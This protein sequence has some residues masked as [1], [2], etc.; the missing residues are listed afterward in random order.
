[1]KSMMVARAGEHR[2]LSVTHRAK[3]CQTRREGVR[4]EGAGGAGNGRTGP[5]RRRPPGL[6]RLKSPYRDGCNRTK[7]NSMP[8][9]QDRLRTARTTGAIVVAVVIA[10]A[11]LRAPGTHDTPPPRQLLAARVAAAS[12]VR[13]ALDELGAA[14]AKT[15]AGVQ[16]PQMSYG[17][18]GTLYA[19]IMNGAP[20]DLFLSA[21]MDYPRQLE[22]AGKAVPGT[23]VAYATGR[24]ALWVT[25]SSPLEVG[26]GDLGVV[27]DARVRHVALANSVHAPYGRAA[28]AA[29]KAAGVYDAVRPRLV[30]GESVAQ[31]LQFVQ[32]GA[33]D[34]GLVALAL[35]KSPAAEA[36]GRYGVVAERLHPPLEQGA[37]V[38]RTPRSDQGRDFE[39]FLQSDEARAVWARF[40]FAPGL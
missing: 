16:A 30:V 19:Q 29:L 26:G 20:F 31:A 10:Y 28:E 38:L 40:G 7:L 36:A 2:S 17:S 13:F 25:A 21:D 18:S 22:A 8:G 5:I 12:D 3:T 33:A 1:M 14:Y 35:A 37:V 27:A 11:W 32:S 9:W 34:V 24:L 4:S 6:N 39:R 23:L 15:H